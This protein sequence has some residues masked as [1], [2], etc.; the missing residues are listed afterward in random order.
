MRSNSSS[1]AAVLRCRVSLF[2]SADECVNGLL[3]IQIHI[4]SLIFRRLELPYAAVWELTVSSLLS[5]TLYHAASVPS[6]R[7]LVR[8]QFMHRYLLPSST[9][10]AQDFAMI[11][12]FSS[13]L[14]HADLAP[15]GWERDGPTK[16]ARR[17]PTTV[18]VGA[19]LASEQASSASRSEGQRID[20]VRWRRRKRRLRD[21][22]ATLWTEREP[23]PEAEPD[24]ATVHWRGEI[25]QR[26]C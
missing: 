5:K 13:Y 10:V 22:G 2:S 23:R 9:G 24:E 18:H 25:K 7:R 12:A 19:R 15:V 6:L 4:I 17:R 20:R 16:G 8:L 26:E 21:S 14:P 3:E 1:G 11:S